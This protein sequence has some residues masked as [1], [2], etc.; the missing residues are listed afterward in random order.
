LISDF[1]KSMKLDVKIDCLPAYGKLPFEDDKFDLSWNFSALWFVDDLI[2]FLSE[3]SRV[4][5]KVMMLTVP[6]RS[7]MG[8]LSQKFFGKSKLKTHLK[9]E[10]IIPRNFLP[11]MKQL[12]WKLIDSDFID[13]PPWPDIG[14]PKEKFLKIFGLHK[15][16]KSTP[17]HPI[18]ITEFYSGNEPDF[19]DKMMSYYWFEKNIPDIVKYFWAHHKYFIFVN[20]TF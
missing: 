10:N 16:I 15:L 1:W 4:T 17:K 3:L 5:S 7:G 6:N 11:I 8:Y 2:K 19:E 12:N 9:E 14:M 18:S 13:C 20:K